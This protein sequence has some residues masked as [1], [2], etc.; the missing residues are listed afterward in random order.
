MSGAP[1]AASWLLVSGDFVTTGGQDAANFHLAA[2][3]AREDEVHLVAHR[4]D[5]SLAARCNVHVRLVPRPFGADLLGEPRLRRAGRREA[6]R[7]ASSGVRVIGNGGAVYGA[8]VN[9]VHCVHA[10]R[11][12]RP[13]G[14]FLRRWKSR[15]VH[16][17]SLR[18]EREALRAAR[19]VI[20]NSERTARDVVDLV[21]V[22]K[23]RVHVVR[24]G[25]SPADFGPASPDRRREARRA[26]G[27]DARPTRPVALFVGTLGDRGKGFDTLY[28]AWRS[29]CADP[30]WDADLAVVGVGADRAHFERRVVADRLTGRVEFLG[31]RSD[32]P[33]ILPAADVL[34]HPAR[35][36]AYGLAVHEALCAGVP[37]IVSARAGVSER[38]T[39]DCP[40]WVLA[41][42]GDVPALADRLR[43]WRRERDAW[44]ARAESLGARLRTW[45]WDDMSREIRRLGL[46]EVR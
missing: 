30:A 3:L 34:V 28:A 22:P 9:W 31:F 42:P 24:L 17:R 13:V 2:Y 18:W 45:T 40:D 41:D 38:L 32:V 15:F 37:A 6:R 1:K 35:Y 5:A 39:P 29:L 14:G 19:V 20:C 27:W 10:A 8:D 4:V 16:R 12:A 11:E 36:D 33:R 23:E 21:G 26:L 46:Y 25:V 43:V 44:S 7:L